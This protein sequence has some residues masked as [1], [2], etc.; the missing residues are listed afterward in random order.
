MKSLLLVLLIG[1]VSTFSYSQEEIDTYE[2]SYFSSKPPQS[3]SVAESEKNGISFYIEAPSMDR[4]KV[5]LI[6]RESELNDFKASIDSAKST[7]AKWKKTAEENNVS[8]I[9]KEIDIDKVKIECAFHY[10]DWNFD[11]SVQVIARFKV[12]DNGEC[13]LI[14]QNKRKLQS[15]SNQYID[16]DGFLIVFNSESEIDSFLNSLSL[17]KAKKHFENKNSK[18]DLFK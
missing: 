3:I 10:G 4:S 18:E 16:A 12:L 17:E 14:I 2:L 6:V 1:L 5:S 9:D 15:S 11:F 8:D 7:Y 13:L